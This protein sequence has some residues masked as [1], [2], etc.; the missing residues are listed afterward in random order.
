M[1]PRLALVLAA[2]LAVTYLVCGIPFGKIVAGKGAGVDIQKVGSGNIGT[3]NVARSVGKLAAALTLFLDAG[4]SFLCCALARPVIGTLVLKADLDALSVGGS[5][6]WVCALVLVAALLG[7]MYSPYM[8]FH[9][10]KGIA[11]GFG[12]M[13][14][15]SW[16]VALGLLVV[17]LAVVLPT[18]IVS[19]ASCAAAVSLPVW[20]VVLERPTLPFVLLM[21]VG[22]AL[23]VWAHRS[24]LGR[25]VRG[26][27]QRFSFHRKDDDER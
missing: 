8:H 13:L 23:V 7:H 25:L 17:W 21:C 18:R 10:G 4:K 26:E 27:E 5:F 3:T 19:A 1:T 2:Y 22:A 24:N 15:I 20:C 6:D 14:A 16:P 9:G 11:V 12:G